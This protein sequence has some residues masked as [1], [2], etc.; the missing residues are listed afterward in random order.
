[1]SKIT[2]PLTQQAI[3]DNAF[4][5]TGKGGGI[6]PSCGRRGGGSDSGANKIHTIAVDDGHNHLKMM[7]TSYRMDGNNNLADTL[8]SDADLIKEKGVDEI[9]GMGRYILDSRL[10][11]LLDDSIPNTNLIDSYK[12]LLRKD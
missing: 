10:L 11:T 1:M 8:L 2:N 3:V 6:D 5:P 9:S 12:K 4:C 7:S